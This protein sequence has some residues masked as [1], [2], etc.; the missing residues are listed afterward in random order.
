MIFQL[1]INNFCESN[2]ILSY[3]ILFRKKIAFKLKTSEKVKDRNII[4]TYNGIKQ[5]ILNII[6]AEINARQAIVGE[7]NKDKIL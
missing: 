3:V 5:N 1:I 6:V 2:L 4:K 7:Y